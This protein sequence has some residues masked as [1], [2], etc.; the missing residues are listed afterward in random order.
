MHA[1]GKQ[2][3]LIWYANRLRSMSAGEITHR[4]TELAKK[5]QARGWEAGWAA[6]EMPEGPLPA[7]P[8]RVDLHHAD[9]NLLAGWRK[10]AASAR[11][12]RFSFLGQDWPD[13]DNASLWHFDP[14]TGREWPKERYCFDIDYRHNEDYGDVKYVWEVNR[15]QYLQPL[16]ALAAKGCNGGLKEFIAAEIESWIDENPPYLG[17][18]WP[19]GIELSLR[20]ITVLVV[21]RL[22]GGAAF[23][24]KLLGKIRAFFSATAT[25]LDRYPSE[26]SSANNHL[27]AEAA[28]LYLIG[29]TLTDHPESACWAKKG[30]AILEREV[31][32][33]ILAD[34]IGAEQSPTYTAFTLEFYLLAMRAGEALGA[35]FSA[36]VYERVAHAGET[37]SWFLDENG[38]C[39]RIGDDDE[40]RVLF[41]DPARDVR[42]VASVLSCLA[43]VCN[44]PDIAPAAAPVHFRN[45]VL[46][47]P[48]LAKEKLRGVKSFVDG[49][50][51]ILRDEIAGKPALFAM[52][53]G[54][55]GYLS[56][57]AHGHADA[58]SLWL[59]CDGVP[60]LADAGT[61]LY[62]SG[63]A[64]RDA[65]RGT[66]L[67]NTLTIG[68]EDQS[69][70][71]GAFNW[72]AKAR[73]KR[74]EIA[75][76]ADN[77]FIAASHD[78]Y[79][80]SFGVEHIRKVRRTGEATF[81]IIDRLIGDGDEALDVQLG[82][83]AGEGVEIVQTNGFFAF[84]SQGAPRM[85]LEPPEGSEPRLVNGAEDE[86]LGFIS[87]RFGERQPAW[88]LV[89]KTRAGPGRRLVTRLRLL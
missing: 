2:S 7:L 48:L 62:H 52:D 66:A 44:R 11:F 18:N 75:E 61:Y 64:W 35:P 78:G 68:G 89:L 57:A 37:L 33:Q 19:S 5:R 49:G 6:F 65:F 8:G 29:A 22:I 39:L 24:K 82:F 69:R 4:F 81:E 42:Y 59:T 55:L 36:A 41:D 17:V 31:E 1:D 47:G 87:Q 79:R 32:K 28:G 13:A 30:R 51:T 72:S 27:I 14:V 45:L 88:Q 83:L 84:I 34:G 20:A 50:Y 73:S 70:I 80:K 10:L 67:H 63:G 56:I 38:H 74:L 26:F 76:V 21:V 54:P 23:E 16:A 40:G 71:A 15:L 58:L 43:A 53:H 86:K 60:L 46:G 77:F 12:R 3:R 85:C 25:W 9:D